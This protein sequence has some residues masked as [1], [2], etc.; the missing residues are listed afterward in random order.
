MSELKPLDISRYLTEAE[1]V[2]EFL[3][4]S[5]EE[6][7]PEVFLK[8]LAEVAKAQGWQAIETGRTSTNPSPPAQRLDMTPRSYCWVRWVRR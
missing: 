4:A 5:R 6:E 2:S 7:D 3:T 1:T 8:A